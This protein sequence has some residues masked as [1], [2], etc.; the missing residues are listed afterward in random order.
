MNKKL[1]YTIC[2]S[3]ISAFFIV[4]IILFT[5]FSINKSNVN[6]NPEIQKNSNIQ[7]ITMD[8]NQ[9]KQNEHFLVI[10]ENEKLIVYHISDKGE[11][12]FYDNLNINVFQLRKSDQE[13]FLKGVTIKDKIELAHLIEDYTS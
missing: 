4:F 12:T 2:S 3:V 6:I 7:N 10:C 8:I 13:A 5:F 11:K 9:E 1:Y